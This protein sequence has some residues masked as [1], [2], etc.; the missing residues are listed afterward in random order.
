MDTGSS[1]LWVADTSCSN[2]PTSAQLFDPTKSSTFKVSNSAT[3]INYGSGQVS[4]Q[5]AQD[6]VSM[7]GFNIS[8]QGFRMSCLSPPLVEFY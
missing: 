2:C 1:D 5:L 6:A 3:T 4:G 8:N 7:G